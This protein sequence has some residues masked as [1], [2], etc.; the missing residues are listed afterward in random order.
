MGRSMR[1]AMLFYE[2]VEE[3]AG[4]G[5]GGGHRQSPGGSGGRSGGRKD[6][7][8]AAVPFSPGA[9][10]MGAVPVV[11]QM[12][13]IGAVCLGKAAAPGVRHASRRH[14]GYVVARPRNECEVLR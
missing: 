8:C 4:I 7:K 6:R 3:G 12:T 14:G 13:V 5:V 9:G 2:E 10:T 11:C 1:C